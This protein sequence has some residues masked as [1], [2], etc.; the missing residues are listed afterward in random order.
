MTTTTW[1]TA[2]SVRWLAWL[3]R[4]QQST[5]WAADAQQAAEGREREYR[6]TEDENQVAVPAAR[7]AVVARAEDARYEYE[8]YW[9]AGYGR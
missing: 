9:L 5:E 4:V 7:S 8:A 1:D 2:E 6:A 3:S